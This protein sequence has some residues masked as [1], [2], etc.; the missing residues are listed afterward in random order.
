M[1]EI[2]AGT[3]AL[4]MTCIPCHCEE[5]E[6][7]RSNPKHEKSNITCTMPEIAAGT[8][9]LAMTCTPAM[10]CAFAMMLYHKNAM[11]AILP[12]HCERLYRVIARRAKPD[13]AIP[14]MRKVKILYKFHACHCEEGEARRSNPRHEKVTLRVPCMRLP[15]AQVPS[16]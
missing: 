12:H 9:A 6:A 13:E 16:Q 11:R 8:S 7:R 14:D 10:T 2:A 3:S 5:G 4:A 1:P 15:R